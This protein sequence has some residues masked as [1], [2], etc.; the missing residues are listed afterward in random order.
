[1]SIR[2]QNWYN[3][4]STRSYP[5][6]ESS[7]AVDD[8]G[9]F[10]RDDILVDCH[11]RFSSDLGQHLYLQGLTVSAGLVTAVFGVATTLNTAGS[12][13]AS[14][15]VTRPGN[16]YTNY[17][18]VPL[19]A[20]V[21]GWVVFG[22][23]IDTP[24]VGR[25]TSPTQALINPRCGRTYRP[26]PVPSIGKINLATSLQGVV[27]IT[28]TEPVIAEYKL[29]QYDNKE[30]RAIVFRLDDA[31]LTDTYNPFTQFLPLCANR[32]E[33][34]T[35]Y[36]QPITSIGGIEPDCNGN[37]VIEGDSGISINPFH[38]CGGAD[39]TT[40]R[41]LGEACEA[42]KP[43]RPTEYEDN[44][45]V[46]TV[47]GDTTANSPV[48][49]NA[50]NMDKIVLNLIVV[51]LA[52]PSDAIVVSVNAIAQTITLSKSAT[53]SAVGVTLKFYKDESDDFCWPDVTIPTI[54]IIVDETTIYP[55]RNLPIVENFNSCY[56]VTQF[57]T[58]AGS[59]TKTETLAPPRRTSAASPPN[60]TT[61]TNHFVL[62]TTGYSTLN[63]ITIKNGATDWAYGHTLTT[64][65]KIGVSGA[66]RNG[67]IVLNYAQRVVNNARITTYIA[68]LIDVQRAQIVVR[69]YTNSAY[70]TDTAVDFTSRP[71]TWY[72]LAVT[73]S[74]D[75]GD[76]ISITF[77]V[78]EVVA[79]DY[80]L[81]GTATFLNCV[82]PVG[83]SAPVCQP[84]DGTFGIIAAQSQTFFN[85]FT[86]TE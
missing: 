71:D 79:N 54:D 12:T 75:G 70:I 85:S 39:M 78:S 20:G 6:D 24:F 30:M 65:L 23:G 82:T 86:V 18:I 5:L 73:P 21:S 8:T 81:H 17:S 77:D 31:Q 33:S 14:V 4:Q 63:I 60:P 49:T 3:L 13:I 15:T 27:A 55:P 47:I 83:A 84:T 16:A 38:D 80:I 48:I 61:L 72:R 42:L 10:I 51:G 74:F 29:V 37:I 41:S 25:Y 68:V 58:Q 59:T 66:S 56:P 45:C 40:T 76:N 52:V 57:D 67:G 2:N 35:C 9:A 1:M 64:E 53:A 32:P 7:T 50:Q 36:K 69:R 19:V 43:K 44:C 26:L 34:G 62:E 11:I 46:S 28:G 22:P